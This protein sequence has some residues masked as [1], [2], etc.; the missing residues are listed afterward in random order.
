MKR[1]EAQLPN[2]DFAARRR[3]V[4]DRLG[5]G[6]AV[7]RAPS[8]AVHAN[9]VE[10]RYRPD[11]NFYYLTGF[12]EPGAV[13]VLDAAADRER[14][15]L[16]VQ[17]RDPER[18][19]WTGRRA[20][21]EG[22]IMDYGADAAYP[23]EELED[24]LVPLIARAE[25]LF[26]HLGK[27]EA[28]DLQMLDLARRAWASRP[29][30][31]SGLPHSIIDPGPIVHEMRLF[32]SDA[33]IAWM[34][35][36]IAIA[37]EAH[38][39]AMRETRPDMRENE[40]EALVEYTFRRRGASGWAY[41]SIIAGGENAT[42][43]HYTANRDRLR[44]GELLLIDAGAELD[45]YCA[46]ITRTFPIGHD[47]LP[48]Q[49]RAYEIVLAAQLEGIRLIRPGATVDEV[50]DR[51]LGVL[52]DGLCSL[53][54]LSEPRDKIL[55]EGLYRPYYMHR[56]SH[57]LGMDVHD[58]GAYRSGTESRRLEPGMVLTVEP[59]LYFSPQL[60]EV[61][62]EYRGIGIRIEDDVLVTADGHEV[63]SDAVPKSVEDVLAL[64]AG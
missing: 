47:F 38:R 55:A 61:P 54:L 39:E 40:I 49:R 20:G 32:K 37:A 44:D 5:N 59:G 62:D 57:W 21:V 27:D 11:S 3:T 2:L 7:F 51:A 28:L 9:D 48:P 6:I 14:F 43:L 46:D 10:Y 50:H 31:S 30:A 17:P 60:G 1:L 8:L 52:V 45:C 4:L 36:A 34:R 13:A 18:E 42:V 58:V 16:F 23:V 41:P 33:E 53:G 12:A 15:L 56:T 19:A 63:L 35:R 64:R 22:A 26:Y 24:R 25:Q 29:R